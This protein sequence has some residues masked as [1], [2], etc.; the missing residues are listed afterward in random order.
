MNKETQQML[1]ELTNNFYAAQSK[2]FSAT[3]HSAWQ[4]WARCVE[5]IADYC[6]ASALCVLDVGCGNMRFERYLAGALLQHKIAF[7]TI[8]NCPELI[9]EDL[10]AVRISHHEIDV[11][12]ALIEGKQPWSGR[13]APVDVACSFGVMHHVPGEQNRAAFLKVLLNSV[14]PGGL[15]MVSL[16]RFMEVPALAAKAHE[17]LLEALHDE[18]LCATLRV[19]LFELA[20]QNDYL[21]GWQ[22][23]PGAY[24][25]CHS[26][27]DED[28]ACLLAALGPDAK[29]VERFRADGRSGDANEYLILQ[30]VS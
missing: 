23:K 19:Q 9:P 21:L 5:A 30:R 22:N 27:K 10:P 2:S 6:D 24:R 14:K 17:M 3:R 16:W 12:G 7:E 13:I 26:F 4:G 18:E 8:D 1:A 29:P 15:V 11:V 25:Y 20:R 28:I